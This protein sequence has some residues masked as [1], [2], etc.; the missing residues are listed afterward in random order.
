MSYIVSRNHYNYI[1]FTLV[2]SI[3]GS[4]QVVYSSLFVCSNRKSL[5]T[6][7]VPNPECLG[8][9]HS[10]STWRRKRLTS[11]S[12][13][14]PSA[15]ASATGFTLVVAIRKGTHFELSNHYNC[16]ESNNSNRGKRSTNRNCSFGLAQVFSSGR[17]HSRIHFRSCQSWLDGRGI[18]EVRGLSGESAVSGLV[19]LEAALPTGYGVDRDT[20][21]HYVHSGTAR[22]LRH[23][24]TLDDGRAVFYFDYVSYS[25]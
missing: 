25:L 7:T 17:N 4:I 2:R 5:P 15:S 22:N 13:Q 14:F 21:L 12:T 18:G 3:H 16:A 24:H 11:N 1:D 19:V 6:T 10:A 23:A 20:L 9:A 8:S